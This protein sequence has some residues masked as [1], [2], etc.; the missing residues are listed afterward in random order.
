MFTGLIEKV[1]I[2]D[3]VTPRGNYLAFTI[4]AEEPFEN[5]VD[6]ESIAIS[7]PCLTVVSHDKRTFTLE[8]SQETLRVTTLHSLRPGSR[9]NVERA[10]RADARLGGHFVAGHIDCTSKIKHIKHIGESFQVTVEML[11]K[12]SPYVIDKGSVALDGISLTII[13]VTEDGF[14]VNLI[15]ETQQRTTWRDIK[16][17]DDINVEFDMVGKYI[18]RF[19]EA[20][21]RPGKLT[22]DAMRKMGY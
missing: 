4:S 22:I 13:E 10:L 5:V 19:L 14:T 1:G 17:G 20:R 8:A 21:E 6:G 12:Y 11:P 18:L 15:P 2:V 16:V 9:V 3:R 7:G